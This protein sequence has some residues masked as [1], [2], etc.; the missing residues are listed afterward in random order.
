MRFNSGEERIDL[1]QEVEEL[2]EFV[3]FLAELDPIGRDAIRFRPLDYHPLTFII[4]K[5][6]I[7]HAKPTI[8]KRPRVY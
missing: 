6:L 7:K 1:R 8:R 3:K 4:V 5:D 2:Y